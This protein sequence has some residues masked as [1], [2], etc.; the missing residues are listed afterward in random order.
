MHYAL[1]PAIALCVSSCT[2][3]PAYADAFP[4]GFKPGHTIFPDPP[5]AP[6]PTPN[7]L[8][9]SPKLEVRNPS[10]RVQLPPVLG[11]STKTLIYD[12]PISGR[13]PISSPLL[14]ASWRGAPANWKPPVTALSQWNGTPPPPP[15]LPPGMDTPNEPPA[16]CSP[17]TP[18]PPAPPNEND[19][20]GPVPVLG[21]AAAYGWSRKLRKRISR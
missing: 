5:A 13:G 15:G 4:P 12:G 7:E 11:G 21:A 3:D 18:E 16:C 19:V 2:T 1:L 14:I 20:P 9:I 8:Q 17:I 10:G 6:P